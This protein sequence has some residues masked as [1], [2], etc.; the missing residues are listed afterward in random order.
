MENKILPVQTLPIILNFLKEIGLEVSLTPFDEESFL[1][2]IMIK[3]GKLITDISKLQH[4]GDLLHEAGHLAVTPAAERMQMNGNADDD[5]TQAQSLEMAAIC[6][7]YAALVHL[8][9]PPG[10]VFHAEGYRGA[11]D[12][13]IENYTS[14]NFIGLPLL[15]WMG[16]CGQQQNQ[17]TSPAFPYMQKWLRD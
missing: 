9:L 11:S 16:L 3:D 2:G 13:Y 4:P 14:G 17:S 1:P 7:S 5:K 12:W 10:T 8:C 6:W 15:Q